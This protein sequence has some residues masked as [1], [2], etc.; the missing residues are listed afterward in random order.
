[1][2]QVLIKLL[3]AYWNIMDVP[4]QKFDEMLSIL[5]ALF[6]HLKAQAPTIDAYDVLTL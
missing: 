3:R 1:M 6:D 2:Q 4:Y 5:A